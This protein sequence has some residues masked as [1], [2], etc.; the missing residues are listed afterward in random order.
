[1]IY[2]FNAVDTFF[3]RSSLP[4]DVSAEN[5]VDCVFPPLPSVYSGALKSCTPNS[6]LDRKNLNKR[7][8][9]EL[10]GILMDDEPLFAFPQDLHIKFS[11]E[12]KSRFVYPTF[13]RKDTSSYPLEFM[14]N[15][16]ETEK[17][18]LIPEDSYLKKNDFMKYL[19]CQEHSCEIITKD[20]YSKTEY[21]VGVQIE[22]TLRTAEDKKLY[23]ISQIRP[24]NNVSLFVQAEGISV[25]DGTVVKFGGESKSAV[26]SSIDD[27]LNTDIKLDDKFF[28]LYLATPAIFKNG[29]FPWWIKNNMTGIFKFKK[30]FV[31]IKLLCASISRYLPV[32]GFSIYKGREYP[33]K[34]CYA[35]PAGSVYYFA[36]EEGTP[37]DVVKLFHGKCISDY[38]EHCPDGFIYENWDKLKYCDRGFGYSLVG[39]LTEEQKNYLRSEYN[40]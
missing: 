19:D 1:M 23:S 26:I 36:I 2:K 40:V 10:N 34:M 3:F 11:N 17:E 33:R 12:D 15:E 28:K 37:E 6:Y 30:K 31:R 21:R 20:K 27:S 8:K 35:V 4:F 18:N 14:I 22:D 9:I 32:G 5:N 39:K 16:S 25:P 38:R 13:E 24:R 29:W 7:L